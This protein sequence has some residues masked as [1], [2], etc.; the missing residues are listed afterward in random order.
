[1]RLLRIQGTSD[2]CLSGLTVLVN[3][4]IIEMSNQIKVGRVYRLQQQSANSSTKRQFNVER[5]RGKIGDANHLILVSCFTI[6][7][8]ND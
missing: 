1:M 8:L 4:K 2:Q 7:M 6:E 5:E 3:V